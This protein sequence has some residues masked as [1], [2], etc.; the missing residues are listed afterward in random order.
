MSSRLNRIEAR[1]Y[2]IKN[3]KQIIE[4]YNETW[5][6]I[7][8]NPETDDW[9]WDRTETYCCVQTLQKIF[10]NEFDATED[11]PEIYLLRYIRQSLSYDY[12]SK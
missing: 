6:E 12:Y 8:E 10:G 3:E 7:R 5:K 2:I 1:D 4:I 11:D 9:N